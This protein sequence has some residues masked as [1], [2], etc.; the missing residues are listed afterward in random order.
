VVASS[1]GERGCY[2]G[3]GSTQR[4]VRK[5]GSALRLQFQSVHPERQIDSL[6]GGD[7]VP[8]SR[9]KCPAHVRGH[10]RQRF[11]CPVHLAMLVIGRVEEQHRA[12]NEPGVR[13]RFHFF[14]PSSALEIA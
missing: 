10:Q 8:V 5:T 3:G 11:E 2:L 7:V 4:N 12:A 9:R 13:L 14:L 1:A 6:L